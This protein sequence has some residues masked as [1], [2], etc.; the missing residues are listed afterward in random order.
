MALYLTNISLMHSNRIMSNVTSQLDTVYKRLSSGFRINSAKDDPAGFQI[1]NRLTSQINGYKQGRRNANDGLALAQCMEGALDESVNMFQRI[2]V[3]ALQAANGIY[4]TFER[5]TMDEE[6]KQ[7]CLEITR[8]AK[9]TT[10]AGSPILDKNTLGLFNANGNI[11]IQVSGQAGDVISIP[12]TENGLSLSGLCTTL[13]LSS[14]N[15]VKKDIIGN[16]SFSLTSAE[17]AQDLLKNIDKYIGNIDSYRGLLGGIQNRFESVIRLNGVMEENLS[18]ARSRI[19]DTDYAEEAANLAR[20]T[21]QQQVCASL[22]PRIMQSKSI[23]LS[24]LQ[25]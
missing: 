19:R 11:D 22:M 8:I 3:L 21:V 5:L 18:D 13:N 25:G 20:L 4:A 24:L 12:G 10:Y 6:V 17:N 23:I 1:A 16:V 7:L 14:E 15:F 2:R 9:K